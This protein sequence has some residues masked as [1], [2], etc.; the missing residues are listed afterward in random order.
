M[1]TNITDLLLQSLG[2]Q[3]LDQVVADAKQEMTPSAHPQ[4]WHMF[5]KLAAHHTYN[6]G[7][8]S[9]EH[10]D[11]DHAMNRGGS[12]NLDRLLSGVSA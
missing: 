11:F 3:Q 8:E 2:D 5:A 9:D 7:K 12:A 10:Y 6:L 1:F 4:A